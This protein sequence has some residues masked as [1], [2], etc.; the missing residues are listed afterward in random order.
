V[1][2]V[3]RRVELGVSVASSRPGSAAGSVDS[4]RR[5]TVAATSVPVIAI[6]GVTAAHVASLLDAG[7]YGV[8]VISAISDATDPTAATADLLRALGAGARA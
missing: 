6:G 2:A 1:A 7:A 8:A 4:S 3:A 5:A